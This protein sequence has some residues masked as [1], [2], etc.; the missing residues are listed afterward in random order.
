MLKR[1]RPLCKE[2]LRSQKAD[3]MARKRREPTQLDLVKL[4]SCCK[5]VKHY[6]EF[7]RHGAFSGGLQYRCKECHGKR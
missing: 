3:L 2:C 6:S 1:G 7:W 5:A 4:C